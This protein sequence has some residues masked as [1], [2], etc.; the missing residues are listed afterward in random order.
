MAKIVFTFEDSE[1]GPKFTPVFDPPLPVREKLSSE[2]DDITDAQ[3]FALSVLHVMKQIM[4]HEE[5]H[6]ETHGEGCCPVTG[7][8]AQKEDCS[9]E[10]DG[11]CDDTS[12]G[13]C[14]N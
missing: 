5:G 13:C 7:L 2:D 3:H 6:G 4:E 14:K 12:A 1:N 8:R 10:C 11:S 9:G